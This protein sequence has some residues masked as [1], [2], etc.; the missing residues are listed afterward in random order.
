M[1]Y[2]PGVT[3]CEPE[4]IGCGDCLGTGLI[5][6]EPCDV[7][8]DTDTIESPFAQIL[9]ITTASE[10]NDPT[11]ARKALAEIHEIAA[12]V[13]GLKNVEAPNAE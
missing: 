4:I 6:D 5:G 7:C 12:R 10:Y 1:T 9:A 2:P 13:S 11:D 8:G 3:G